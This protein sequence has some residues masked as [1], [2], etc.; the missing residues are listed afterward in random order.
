[1]GWVVPP[2]GLGTADMIGSSGT[3]PL[4]VVGR[5]NI[6]VPGPLSNG[7]RRLLLRA[8]YSSVIEM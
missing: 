7:P 5:A 6:Y 3:H 1:M 8:R 2:N 4:N